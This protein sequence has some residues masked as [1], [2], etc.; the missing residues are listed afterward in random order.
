M[1]TLSP[2]QVARALGVSESSLKRWCDRGL[3][4]ATTTP[5]RHRRLS[6]QAVLDFLRT[7]RRP[8][9]RPELLGLPLAA[10][11]RPSLASSEP[12][13]RF[14]AALEAGDFNA[15]RRLLSEQRALGRKLSQLGDELIAPAFER[16]GQGWAC[17]EVEVYQERRCVEVCGRLLH[18]LLAEL[19]APAPDAPLAIGGAVD[20]DS[21]SLPTTLVELVLA[22]NGW[23]AKSMG[24]R[25]P[26]G[27]LARAV[28]VER[29]RL[30]WISASH[31][32]DP[33]AFVARFDQFQA[34]VAGSAAIVVGGRALTD[35]IRRRIRYSAFCDNLAHLESFL[36]T[37]TL[38]R[39][40]SPTKEPHP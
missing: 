12:G 3:I 6:Q 17:G 36:A 14:Q 8:L 28:Q 22:E 33:E 30:V 26:M 27:S 1:P 29:P 25:L 35:D 5:G 20:D 19:P 34:Q 11:A 38:G 32:S 21:Y 39:S 16:I 7:S 2:R 13:G 18:E 24:T 31:I 40:T 37:L 10:A 4:T 23:Q 9:V 15:I